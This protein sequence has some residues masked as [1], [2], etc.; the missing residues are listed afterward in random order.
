[1]KENTISITKQTVIEAQHKIEENI[2]AF[3]L[4]TDP[5]E[6]NE[7]TVQLKQLEA[8]YADA[9]RLHVYSTYMEAE[10]PMVA[11]AKAYD[12][13]LLGHKDKPRK[14]VKDGKVVVDVVRELSEKDKLHD[15][16][17]FINWAKVEKSVTAADD[18]MEKMTAAREAIM[19]QW[20]SLH[21]SG[22]TVAESRVS[23]RKMQDALQS[24]VD[25]LI[26][27]KGE[28]GGNA[29]IV[30]RDA[31][32]AAFTFC[33]TRKHGLVGTIMDKSTWAKLKMDILHAAVA[34]KSFTFL[35]GDEGGAA[36]T[37]DTTEQPIEAT[38][39]ESTDK[40]PSDKKGSGKKSSG[41]KK[42]KTEPAA[43]VATE[44]PAAES[45]TD[46]K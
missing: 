19:N 42:D 41:K 29:V 35:Y 44:Q 18:Y 46:N 21:K 1:M 17:D 7:L 31:V 3:N 15:V 27:I 16:D 12:Y 11:F 2:T 6:R 40:K 5:A 9:V 13:K 14:S 45:T 4:S 10:V 24:M 28:K 22:E 32:K 43:P 8:D 39:T 38:Q 23:W 37:D 33:T 20:K 30:K 34:G 36:N 25:A 26:F